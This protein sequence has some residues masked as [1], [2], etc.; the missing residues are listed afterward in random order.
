MPSSPGL[1]ASAEAEATQTI[2]PPTARSH[3]TGSARRR[4]RHRS[5][6][7]PGFRP[8]LAAA[9]AA[10]A[11]AAGPQRVPGLAS[12]PAPE[13]GATPWPPIPADAQLNSNC[14]L[15]QER[16]TNEPVFG[17]R[18]RAESPCDFQRHHHGLHQLGGGGQRVRAGGTVTDGC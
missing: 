8:G 15:G 7:A 16:E 9:G 13:W 10:S 1:A 2:I 11:G 3:S 5:A 6:A 18:A 17:S 12:A 4:C 14:S